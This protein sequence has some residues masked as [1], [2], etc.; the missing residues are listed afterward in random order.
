MIQGHHE[1]HGIILWH[2]DGDLLCKRETGNSHDPQAT[3]IKRWSKVL[4]L[5]AVGHVPKKYH[6]AGIFWGQLFCCFRGFHCYLENLIIVYKCSDSP[7]NP[8]NLISKIYHWAVT[9]KIFSLENYPLY[10][11]Y[12]P[13]NLFDNH[14]RLYTYICKN[15]ANFTWSSISPNFSSTKVSLQTVSAFIHALML[16]CSWFASERHFQMPKTKSAAT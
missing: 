15:L 6:I 13:I 3:T 7:V 5:Q 11:I 14:M 2:A 9:L 12:L 1:Y 4:L 10:G 16:A 8:Q